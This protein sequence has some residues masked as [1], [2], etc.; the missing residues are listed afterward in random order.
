MHSGKHLLYHR[1]TIHHSCGKGGDR[2]QNFVYA[3]LNLFCLAIL[4]LIS[5]N[6]YRR[7]SLYLPDQQLYLALI[8]TDALILILD[9]A[10]R[11]FDGMPGTAVSLA[12]P[13]AYGC[14]LVLTPVICA[15]WNFYADYYIHKSQSRLKKIL[16]PLMI[17][18]LANVALV[19]L[20]VSG[21]MLFVIDENNVS[22]HG[23]YFYVTAG[24]GFLLC[25]YSVGYVL[26]N[27][28]RLP[29]KEFATLL[30]FPLFLIAGGV[31]QSVYDGLS[32]LWACATFSLLLTFINIQN[33]QLDTD[34]LTNLHN[35]RQLDNYLHVRSQRLRSKV[36]AGVM[37][38]LDSFKSIN[39]TYGH[40]SGDR[41]LK[42]VADIL[43]E[44]FRRGDFLARY[45][46]DEFVVVMTLRDRADLEKIMRR[47]RENVALFNAKKLVPYEI[48][49]SA[50]CEC[51]SPAYASAADFLKHID[52]LMYLDKQKTKISCAS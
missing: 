30:F 29:S 6:I 28:K 21:G 5:L 11:L 32:L 52:D 41:A 18:A 45:G 16:L 40:D 4:L 10:M 23:P 2:I 8:L 25:A 31:V 36:M 50:G 43:R 33:V 26:L 7:S 13:I 51:Y 15:L 17:P 44:T 9:S 3:E 39:D 49:L 38:D 48:S 24:I 37:I 42:Y 22:R 14:Y 46:G 34:Y 1:E 19:I 27:R 35:R 20:N 47:L 12:Y